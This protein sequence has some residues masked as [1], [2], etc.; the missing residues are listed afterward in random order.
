VSQ[1][2]R[3]QPSSEEVSTASEAEIRIGARLKHERVRRGLSLRGLAERSGFS[4]SFL[5]Q[6]E[7]DQASPSLASLG[8]LAHALGVS[9]ASLVADSEATAGPNVLRSADRRLLRSE[10][11]KATVSSLIPGGVDTGTSVLLIEM[12]VGGCSGNPGHAQAGR[13]LAYCI[14]GQV[15]LQLGAEDLRLTE[16]DCASYDVAAG[17]QWTNVGRGRC[18]LLIVG[19]R[20]A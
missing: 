20:S 16:G 7:L 4:A 11:S 15:R 1:R 13:E 3:P 17:P 10:W 18:Q 5:S 14:K 6:V 12:D 9:L 19:M 8:R 2:P